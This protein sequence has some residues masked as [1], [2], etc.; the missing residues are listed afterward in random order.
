MDFI[1]EKG[2]LL[3]Q[4]WSK[5]SFWYRLV[6]G[7]DNCLHR[8]RERDCGTVLGLEDDTGSSL[9]SF[10]PPRYSTSSFFP[11]SIVFGKRSLLYTPSCPVSYILLCRVRLV[12]SLHRST[13][14]PVPLE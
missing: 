11:Y 1:S 2:L 4:Y 7:I 10:T 5:K 8:D 14:L 13:R 3:C 12:S 9:F 6:D